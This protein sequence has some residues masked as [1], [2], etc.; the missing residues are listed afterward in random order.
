LKLI[1]ASVD[2]SDENEDEDD[3]KVKLS[4]A[5]QSGKAL[6]QVYYVEGSKESRRPP[7]QR[8]WPQ[9][10]FLIMCMETLFDSLCGCCRERN[11]TPE[12]ERDDL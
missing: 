12:S 2:I 11:H 5:D 3:R 1:I 4:F 8:N 9:E 10:N 6:T 7:Y